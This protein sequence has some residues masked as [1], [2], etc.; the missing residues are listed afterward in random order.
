MNCT[1]CRSLV[2]RYLLR[3]T[4]AWRSRE[5]STR[6]D[7]QVPG[8]ADP[9]HVEEGTAPVGGTQHLP[10]E[11]ADMTEKTLDK[12]DMPAAPAAQQ[13]HEPPAKPTQRVLNQV[14]HFHNIMSVA[15]PHLTVVQQGSRV[16]EAVKLV[17]GDNLSILAGQ[18]STKWFTGWSDM[19]ATMPG[20]DDEQVKG[21]RTQQSSRRAALGRPTARSRT[22]GAASS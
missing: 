6:T 18:V 12:P 19:V 16:R 13:E 3:R 10:S 21:I 14:M 1:R 9:V 5:S 4:R 20:F 22:S 2:P 15:K 7:H 8:G 11:D 17:I